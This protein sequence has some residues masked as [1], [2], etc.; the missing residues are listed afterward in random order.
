MDPVKFLDDEGVMHMDIREHDA[1]TSL[2]SLPTEILEHILCFLSIEDIV[3]VSQVCRRL[4][5]VHTSEKVWRFGFKSRYPRLMQTSC[6]PALLSAFEWCG[7]SWRRTAWF[8]ASAGRHLRT[9]LAKMAD[10]CY[11][12]GC[13]PDPAM[14]EF[15]SLVPAHGTLFNRDALLEVIYPRQHC[16]DDDLSLRYY[17]RMLFREIQRDSVLLPIIREYVQRPVQHLNVPEAFYLMSLWMIPEQV[18]RQSDLQSYYIKTAGLVLDELRRRLPE[19]PAADWAACKQNPFGPTLWTDDEAL[20]LLDVLNVVLYDQLALMEDDGPEDGPAAEL[21]M[22]L[23]L[24]HRHFHRVGSKVQTVMASVYCS[25]AGMLGVNLHNMQLPHSW[26][27]CWHRMVGEQ[28]MFIDVLRRGL[29]LS[30]EQAL[31]ELKAVHP[32]IDLQMLEPVPRERVLDYVIQCSTQPDPRRPGSDFDLASFKTLATWARSGCRLDTA[33]FTD[34]MSTLARMRPMYTH[35]LLQQ[36]IQANGPHLV[37]NDRRSLE[38]LATDLKTRYKQLLRSLDKQEAKV[39]KMADLRAA[40]RAVGNYRRRFGV[41]DVVTYGGGH[42]AVVYSCSPCCEAPEDWVEERGMNS[43]LQLGVNQPFY[44]LLLEVD[45]FGYMAEE[46]LHLAA[47]PQ[48]IDHVEVGRFFARFDGERYVP[49]APLAIRFPEP[50]HGDETKMSFVESPTDDGDSD[51]EDVEDQER[52]KALRPA[53][54]AV[55]MGV[56]PE[57]L[58]EDSDD[59]DTNGGAVTADGG[60]M[61]H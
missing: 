19:H 48:P 31:E 33:A 25:V 38:A 9:A 23:F 44:K 20:Q 18:N 1:E 58:P 7:R 61:D 35:R 8:R 39:R 17:A 32:G 29:R 26:M 15:R 50:Q 42:L 11:S 56:W 51:W 45:Q 10:R 27:I 47:D 53:P 46:E 34:L 12:V 54:P 43:R 6:H 24:H 22:L 16:P 37:E 49:I 52:E 60:Q 4:H 57:I 14:E 41:G 21:S 13:L 3:S 30:R 5:D 40:G 28:Y 36:F 59:E 55:W 2:L